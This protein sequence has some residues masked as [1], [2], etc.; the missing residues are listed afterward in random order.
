VPFAVRDAV[1]FIPEAA[2]VTVPRDVF[3]AAKITLPVGAAL[4][5]A[6]FTLTVNTIEALWE[7]VD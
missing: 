2:S 1:A 7:I 4:P 3:P 5:L 6:G